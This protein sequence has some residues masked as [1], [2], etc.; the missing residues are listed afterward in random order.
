MT[1]LPR[2]DYT[3]VV[4]D[5]SYNLWRIDAILDD[6]ICQTI[7]KSRSE[8]H[9]YMFATKYEQ[10]ARICGDSCGT[11]IKCKHTYPNA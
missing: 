11:C 9:A 5:Q 6:V 7:A 8:D 1:L 3:R 2:L 10:G 4:W